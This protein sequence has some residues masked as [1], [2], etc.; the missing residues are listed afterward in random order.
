MA[1]KIG[2]HDHNSKFENSKLQKNEKRKKRSEKMKNWRGG[3]FL[4]IGDRSQKNRKK[5]K[6]ETTDRK[7]VAD[8]RNRWLPKFA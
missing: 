2:W 3:T 6:H 1:T 7:R 5:R 4:A 8:N